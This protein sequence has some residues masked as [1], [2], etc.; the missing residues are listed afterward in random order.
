M[1]ILL[2]RHTDAVS[3]MEDSHRPLSDKGIEQA[4][5]IAS[6]IAKAKWTSK[7]IYHSGILRA[8]ETANILRDKGMKD[9]ELKVKKSIS[10]ESEVEDLS[11]WLDELS[12]SGKSENITLVS[13][14]P[15]LESLAGL[16]LTGS[17]AKTPVHV[18]KG[19]ALCLEREESVGGLWRVRW[20]VTPKVLSK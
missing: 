1:K 13:H 9:A 2:V 11:D 6:F 4:K 16:L 18:S 5:Q 17:A 8:E 3:D 20:M 12:H 14:L 7:V 15:F 10:P 19:A